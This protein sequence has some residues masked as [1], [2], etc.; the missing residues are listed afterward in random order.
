MLFPIISKNKF[1]LLLLAVACCLTYCDPA[2]RAVGRPNPGK[3]NK[4]GKYE[5]IDT[6]RWT[7]NNGKPPIGNDRPNPG[8]QPPRPGETYHIA[9]LL[10][11]LT[12]QAEGTTVPDKSELALQFYAG[13]KIALQK[14][15]VEEGLNLVVD[16]FDTQAN[17]A[18]F[19][20]LINT[21]KVDKA[22]LYIGPIRTSHVTTF[23]NWAKQR[24]RILLSPESVSVDL[25]A[26]NPGFLQF[27]PS[28][29][30]HC[31][32]ITRY[33]R[34]HHKPENVTLVCKEKEADR[35][36]YFQNANAAL[37]GARFA[38]MIVPDATTTFTAADLKKYLRPGKT[39]IFILPTWAS[40]DFV[41]A[42]L[43]TLKT[44]K[45][46]GSVEVYGMPQWAGYES[47]E[48]EYLRDLNVHITQASF[49]DHQAAD[50]KL[51]QQ[52][53]YEASG[54][55]PNDDAFNGYDVTLF[56]GRMLKKYGLS[57]PERLANESFTGLQNKFVFGP[58]FTTTT[59]DAGFDRYDYLENTAV[60][61]LRF[62]KFGFVPAE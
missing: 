20:Q 39:S 6:V 27:N 3:P 51:F 4:P 32:A 35:L 34:A 23:A 15:S 58:V 14:L 24:R 11:F 9:Y 28:L 43:R 31:A 36:P 50:V 8:N 59:P 13:A 1:L 52:A 2:K 16:A 49:V 44:V 47:I 40:Q 5:P 41:M 56:A 7:P 45:G 42:F 53:F 48:P 21:P 17:D 29:R 26:Q 55:L 19:Q 60:H 18:D 61:I 37:G 10:P 12:A 57:F 46:T 38:E 25:T 22:Q 33:V 30:A 54:T 62:D